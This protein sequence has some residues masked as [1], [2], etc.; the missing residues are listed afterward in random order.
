MVR[1]DDRRTFG[2]AHKANA[3]RPQLRV[4]T[5]SSLVRANLEIKKNLG[6]VLG[7]TQLPTRAIFFIKQE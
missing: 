1:L 7:L 5:S 3:T 2:G 6:G 4:M